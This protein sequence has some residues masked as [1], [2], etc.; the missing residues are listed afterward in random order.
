MKTVSEVRVANA[1]VQIKSKVDKEAPSGWSVI[2]FTPSCSI[3]CTRT[4]DQ[5][6]CECF[7]RAII[8]A[9]GAM[10]EAQIYFDRVYE[11]VLS[12]IDIEP[13]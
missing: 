2:A 5:Q 4:H 9:A 8:E 13:E 10:E 6:W 11:A 1:L 7:V 12:I 3:R